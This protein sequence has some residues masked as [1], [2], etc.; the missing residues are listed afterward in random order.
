MSTLSQIRT[1]VRTYITETDTTNTNFIDTELN[2]FINEGIRF[3]GALVKKP[4]DHATVQVEENVPAYTLPTDA[5]LLMTAYFGN[6]AT[7]GDVVPIRIV[8]EEE[9]REMFPAWM[10]TTTSTQGRPQFAVL[11]DR[12]T[13]LIHPRPN[14]TEAVSGKTLRVGYVYQPAVI[15]SDASEPDLPIVYHDLVAQ[16]GAH[17]C[18][19]S[20]LN[21][22][23]LGA[24]LLTQVLSKAKKLENLIVKDSDALGFHWG[25]YVDPDDDGFNG[26]RL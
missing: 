4:I 21:K 14:A 18:Y 20:K 9:L 7:N 2:G 1:L 15:S 25:S 13:I 8:P 16:Y 11:L 22:P 5:V 19:M 6:P 10:D 23:D 24:A 3:L 12:R 17:M 26:L